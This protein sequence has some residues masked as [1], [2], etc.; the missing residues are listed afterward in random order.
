MP[1]PG[2]PTDMQPQMTAML[3]MAQG[4]SIVTEGVWDNRM[5]Y[6][7]ELKRMGAKIQ[8]DAKSLWWKGFHPFPAH[9]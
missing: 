1:H 3:T 8:V 9:R 5:R 4:T 2:F 6:T 7:D